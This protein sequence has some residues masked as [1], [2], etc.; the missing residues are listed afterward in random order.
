MEQQQQQHDKDR[1]MVNF[2]VFKKRFLARIQQRAADQDKLF[3]I[4]KSSGL[5]NKSKLPNEL[6]LLIVEFACPEKD[7]HL[8]IVFQRKHIFVEDN[9]YLFSGSLDKFCNIMKALRQEVD[10]QL[11]QMEFNGMGLDTPVD[12]IWLEKTPHPSRWVWV[13]YDNKSDFDRIMTYVHNRA[14]ASSRS[15][16]YDVRIL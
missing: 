8:H 13:I 1:Q 2:P 3:N 4:I 16:K 11:N 7:Y 10:L 6:W 15:G 5:V 14:S 12:A 9:Y